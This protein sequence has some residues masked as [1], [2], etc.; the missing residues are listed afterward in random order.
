MLFSDT[1]SRES[2]SNKIGQSTNNSYSYNTRRD[3]SAAASA[4]L[5]HQTNSAFCEL[6]IEV[7][8]LDLTKT[9]TIFKV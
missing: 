2:V 6:E 1:G 9:F 7:Q 8:D 5:E 3:F 4:D